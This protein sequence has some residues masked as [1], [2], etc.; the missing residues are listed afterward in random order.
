MDVDILLEVSKNTSTPK[1]PRCIF[2]VPEVLRRHNVLAYTPDIVSIGP[3]HPRGNLQFQ[4]MENLK[5][6]Y[7][8]DLLLH[9]DRSHDGDMKLEASINKLIDYILVHTKVQAMAEFERKARD[10]YAHPFET[11]MK[12]EFLHMMILDGCFLVQIFRKF[13][14]KEQRDIN[15]PLFNMDC[16]FQYICHDLL[17]L[18]NQIPWFVLQYIYELTVKYYQNPEPCL[19]V[20]ILTELSSQPQL[21]HNCRWYRDH[22][23]G[24]NYK[25][26]ESVLHILDLIRTSIVFSFTERYEKPFHDANIQL[27]AS[28]RIVPLMSP[29]FFL[30]RK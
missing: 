20:L 15:D 22:L 28:A 14:N 2:R 29:L 19:S 3:Y 24:N 27:I 6:D 9:M 18:E 16:M 11:L 7:L 13:V 25:E 21:S 4:A 8:R 30:S 5:Y 1:L 23:R 17:L 26:D 10:F 12:T